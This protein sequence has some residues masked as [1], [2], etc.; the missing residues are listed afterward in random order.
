MR[1]KLP[2]FDTS[3]WLSLGMLFG[4]ILAALDLWSFVSAGH[5]AFLPYKL[6][7]ILGIL[8][9]L[10]LSVHCIDMMLYHKY[11]KSWGKMR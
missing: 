4:I 9:G 7:N 11:N 10:S 3:G 6:A 5:N 2:K 8:I 1:A